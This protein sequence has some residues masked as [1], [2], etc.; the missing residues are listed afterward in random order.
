M[1]HHRAHQ[2]LFYSAFVPQTFGSPLSTK[3]LITRLRLEIYKLFSRSPNFPRGFIKPVNPYKM[4]VSCLARDS[5]LE[6]PET[7]SGAFR[8]TLFPLYLPNEGISECTKLNSYFNFP[9]LYIIW[10]DQLYRIERVGVL[11]MTFRARKL[12]RTFVKWAPRQISRYPNTSRL[13][14]IKLSWARPR[15]NFAVNWLFKC[16]R[17]LRSTEGLLRRSQKKR[18]HSRR[19][20]TERNKLNFD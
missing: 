15:K 14:V 2:M 11:R 6:I 8:V 10:K 19:E 5:F 9:S 20:D 18:E 3:L 4:R 17:W 12:F 1:F 7:F 16:R 13:W